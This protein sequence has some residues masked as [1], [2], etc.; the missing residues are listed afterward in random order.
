[1]ENNVPIHQPM[2]WV[3]QLQR[4]TSC[5]GAWDQIRCMEHK[6]VGQKFPSDAKDRKCL[7]DQIERSQRPKGNG[8]QGGNIAIRDF[9]S[10]GKKKL[11]LLLSK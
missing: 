3:V 11:V 4:S 9:N 5:M 6:E 7:V 8:F 10:L 1:M 2:K